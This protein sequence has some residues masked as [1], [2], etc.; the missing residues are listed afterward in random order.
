MR[1]RSLCCTAHC[2]SG[3]AAAWY[4]ESVRQQCARGTACPGRRAR[5]GRNVRVRSWTGLEGRR[6][7]RDSDMAGCAKPRSCAPLRADAPAPWAT[8][9]DD[10]RRDCRPVRSWTVGRFASPRGARKTRLCG[11]GGVR[12]P[13]HHTAQVD[14]R[15]AGVLGGTV[16][17]L[18]MI[19]Q[20]RFWMQ[21]RCT[22]SGLS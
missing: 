9:L 20:A 6:R 8:V 18:E 7:G 22:C 19:Q 12:K 14:A 11:R 17:R 3:S 2:R 10:G 13:A 15:S 21:H 1:A 16:P 5:G 4:R